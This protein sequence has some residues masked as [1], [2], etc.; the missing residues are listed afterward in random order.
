MNKNREI[1]NEVYNLFAQITF[2][3]IEAGF[4]NYSA[5]AILHRMRWHMQIDQGDRE[6][7]CNNNWTPELARWFHETYPEYGKFFRTRKSNMDNMFL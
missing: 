3:T 5:R 2:K 4:K 6:Y 1:P 7:K